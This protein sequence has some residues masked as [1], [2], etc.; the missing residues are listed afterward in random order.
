[1]KPRGS[2]WAWTG[3][4]LAALCGAVLA[5][6]GR[7]ETPAIAGIASQTLLIGNYAEPADLDPQLIYAYTDSNITYALF[8]GLTWIDEESGQPIPAAAQSWQV[9]ADGLV[10]TFHLRPEGRW[11]NGEPV[12]AADFVYS[13]H[14]ILL[15]SLGVQYAYML[16]PIKHARDF[17]SGQ[18]KDFSAVGVQAVDPLTL[19]VT[20]ER[21]TAYLPALAAHN[22]W[23]PVPRATVEKFGRID[24]RGSAW[25]R[26]GN[27]VGN[28]PFLLTEWRPNGR[29]VVT[30]NPHYW[31]AAH[32]RLNRI[33]FFP[34]ENDETE[35]LNFRAG[36]LHMTFNV[37]IS[38]VGMYRQETPR[39]LRADPWLAS[40]FL[41]FNTTRAPLNNP[42]VRRAL[43]Q[44]LDR[45]AIARDVLNSTRTPAYNLTPPNCAG[46]TARAGIPDDV[47]AAQRLLAEAGYPGGRGLP[48]FEALTYTDSIKVRVMEA[49]QAMWRKNLGV[50]I[51]IL[52]VEQKTLFQDEQSHN[53]S[54]GFAGWGADYADPS[55]F[56]DQYV[57]GGGNNWTGWG[58]P[59]YDRL[60][61]AAQTTPDQ[62]R[63]YEDFQKAEAILSQQVPLVPL[64][65]DTHTYLL[66]PAVRGWKPSILGFH[67]YKDVWLSE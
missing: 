45:T 61:A 52:P 43:A 51:E 31:D 19:R 32:V 27:L 9:S 7:R 54:I 53:F 26:A 63:R 14:R 29:V 18:L 47:P 34:I 30:K 12:T 5:G 57:T 24:Q 35:D 42:K 66:H 64:Y 2:G 38:R 21:P 46:F 11:S 39:R 1:M 6:C 60:I 56:L 33:I 17:N 58:D 16:W 36:Q 13:F 20:L 28:G 23:M 67:R 62:A 48:V 22:T 10:Y 3:I 25:T 65:D 50:R 8:E 55:S 44:G 49:I 41:L 4:G 40:Y 15:P 59:D 37:P